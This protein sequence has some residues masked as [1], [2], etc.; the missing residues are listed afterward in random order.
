MTTPTDEWENL[1]MGAGT[2]DNLLIQLGLGLTRRPGRT[3]D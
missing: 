2:A 3:A 1:L